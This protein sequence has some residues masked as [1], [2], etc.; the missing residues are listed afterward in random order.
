LPNSADSGGQPGLAFVRAGLLVAAGGGVSARLAEGHDHEHLPRAVGRRVVRLPVR[1]ARHAA[2]MA[3]QRVVV[4]A[5]RAGPLLDRCAAEG[6][7]DRKR[8]P[9]PGQRPVRFGWHLAMRGASSRQGDL[10]IRVEAIGVAINAFD[11]EQIAQRPPVHER[12]WCRVLTTRALSDASPDIVVGQRP[13]TPMRCGALPEK[14]RRTLTDSPTR[15][16]R[17]TGVARATRARRRCGARPPSGVRRR[18]PARRTRRELRRQASGHART[19][20]SDHRGCAIP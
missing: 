2:S 1:Y 5:E 4:H 3:G 14:V 17:F 15:H 20:R 13:L 6:L 18:L 8:A 7:A 19:A 12:P 16:H 11:V 9:W 10:L